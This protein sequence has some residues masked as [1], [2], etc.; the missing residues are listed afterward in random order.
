MDT[1]VWVTSD[2][3]FFHPL[4]ARLRGFDSVEE[5]D[6]AVIAMWNSQ[7]KPGDHVYHLG[8]FALCPA[9]KTKDYTNKL[10]GNIYLIRG[11]HDSFGN[12]ANRSR[13]F[14]WIKDYH[15]VVVE[16]QRY[17]FSHYPFLSWHWARRGTIMAHGHCHN[18]LSHLEEERGRTFDA[19]FRIDKGLFSHEEIIETMS[20]RKVVADDIKE[21]ECGQELNNS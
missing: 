13:G 4:M 16:G 21:D 20:K 5:H 3:H 1:K 7:V 15:E 10:N 9:G 2:T 19:C 12:S 17:V 18:A 6:K 11:N 8:D 14:S